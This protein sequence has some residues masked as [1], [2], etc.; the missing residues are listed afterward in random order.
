MIGG[1]VRGKVPKPIWSL[2]VLCLGLSVATAQ[3]IFRIGAA[4]PAN[5]R[6]VDETGKACTKG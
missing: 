5:R 3:M 4:K 6:A 2:N 1:D